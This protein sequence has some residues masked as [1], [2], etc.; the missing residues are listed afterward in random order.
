MTHLSR[1]SQQFCLRLSYISQANPN[2]YLNVDEHLFD[3]RNEHL[4]R[5]DAWNN[6]KVSAQR[7]LE[8]SG[9]QI[10]TKE[11][12][13]M[14]NARCNTASCQLLSAPSKM[15]PGGFI[16]WKMVVALTRDKRKLMLSPSPPQHWHSL[17]K[18][19]FF[20]LLC[21]SS[22]RTEIKN[23]DQTLSILMFCWTVAI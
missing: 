17:H 10:C 15:E 19:T 6:G 23:G 9:V 12:R 5:T 20:L 3:S 14:H 16:T 4:F 1:V 2:H 21:Y 18:T 7:P 11:R 22:A 13:K 8:T